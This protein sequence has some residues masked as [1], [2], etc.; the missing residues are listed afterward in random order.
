LTSR[1]CLALVAKYVLYDGNEVY[2]LSDQKTP[3]KFAGQKVL[4][5]GTLDAKT[6][7]IQVASI[8]AA[9]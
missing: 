4:V 7:T 2:T 6:K 3:D 8:S 5:E 9:K 1:R